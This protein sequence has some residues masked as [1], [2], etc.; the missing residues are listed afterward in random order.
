MFD[1]ALLLQGNTLQWRYHTPFLNG[2]RVSVAI[3]ANAFV[4]SLGYRFDG[5]DSAQ[6]HFDIKHSSSIQL[7]HADQ[8]TYYPNPVTDDLMI[9]G[10]MIQDIIAID[11]IGRRFD[12]S[13]EPV[14]QAYKVNMQSLEAGL[15]VLCINGQRTIKVIKH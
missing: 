12:V 10:L 8:L 11:A 5:L 6:W 4:D 9:S 7:N 14:E 2:A 3:Q 1:T 13:L 15:Y